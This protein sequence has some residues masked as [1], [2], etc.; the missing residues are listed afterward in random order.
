MPEMNT[1]LERVPGKVVAV[2]SSYRSRAAER[3]TIPAWPSY[4]LKP[5]SSL[6]ASG[7]PVVRPPGCELLA[8]EGEVALVIGR[9]ARRV[10]RADGWEHVAYLTAA[11]DFG[12]Y[13]LR[14][15]DRGSNVRS[16]GVDGFTPLGPRL[17][18]ARAVDLAALRLR[19][20]VNGDLAQDAW[21]AQDML[22]GFGDIVADLSRLLT[23]EPGDVIL[24]GTPTGSTVVTP[25]DVVEVEVSAG[26]QS[27]GR[28][29]SPIV[30]ADYRL[31]PPGAMPRAGDAER[32]AAYGA[33]HQPP[34][35]PQEILNDLR[36]VA[37][38]TLA[39]VARKR[40]LNT[41]TLDG[42]RST[43]PE[44]K[45]AGY[46]R[47]V[48]YLPLREDLSAAQG[49]MNAQKR[50]IEEIRPGEILVIEARGDPTAGTVGD[51]LALRAQ[52]RGAAGI[53]TDGAIRDSA[54][55]AALSIPIYHAAVHPAV[56]G[57][58]HV[59]WESQVTV[60]CAG[61][62]IQ[63]GDLLVGDADGVVVLP[64]KIAAEVLA[65]AREQERQEQFIAERVAAGES[66]DGLFPLPESRRAEYQAWLAQQPPPEPRLEPPQCSIEP[67]ITASMLHRVG[68][69]PSDTGAA[70]AS[71]A[72]GSGDA[73]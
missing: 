17:I 73:P 55:L 72:P 32:A 10:S 39:A 1:A 35:P 51:I 37:T 60:A 15:A 71:D 36:E 16:K 18:D 69:S 43:R 66:I 11:N 24:T 6:A 7:D 58:R 34:S 49:V 38:A 64:P 48:R 61:V 22:F 12:V 68:G 44:G 2:H 46:A 4:F 41:L 42:L 56:L 19:T 20:W 9:R 47:T 31:E 28:L 62:T 21:P 13:D 54:A 57:R 63:P 52:V 27:S 5:A 53:I 3:G 40:G 29:R 65:E 67:V 8:F 70:D 45:M 59:P 23:L 14:Y 33:S 25:G 26:D 30:E 50:A